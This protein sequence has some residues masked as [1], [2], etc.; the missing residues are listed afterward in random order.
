MKASSLLK[1]LEIGSYIGIAVYSAVKI[2]RRVKKTFR[3]GDITTSYRDSDC[4]RSFRSTI[5]IYNNTQ[6]T[7]AATNEVTNFF[8]KIKTQQDNLINLITKNKANVERLAR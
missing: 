2:H 6:S 8:A 1:F 7:S 4:D 5:N 3:T